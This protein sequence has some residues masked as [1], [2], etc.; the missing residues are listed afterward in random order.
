MA[1]IDDFDGEGPFLDG[2][3]TH[4]AVVVPADGADL[5]NVTRALWFGV[6]GNVAVVTKGGEA[7]TIPVLAGSR[8]DLQV[9]RV[10]ATG[11]TVTAGNII[12][13]W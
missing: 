7:L 11:T 6:G 3:A 8:L 5:T 13:L 4:A 12:A 1:A 10:K 2:P 9:T